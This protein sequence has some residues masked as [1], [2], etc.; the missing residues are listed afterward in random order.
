MSPAQLYR[1][2]CLS[3]H[4]TDGKGTILRKGM[5][6]LP[7]FTDPKWQT[8]QKDDA[9]LVKSIL[10]GKGKFMTPMKEK[11]G[12]GD[13]EKLVALVRGFPKS[14]PVETAPTPIVR[15]PEGPRVEPKPVPAPQGKEPR[16]LPVDVEQAA[17]RTRV[18][19]THYRQYCLSCHGTDGRGAAEMKPAM[20]DLP[21]F[22]LRSWQDGVTNAQ[23]TVSILD[24]KGTLM[25]AFRGRISD[26]EAQD[27]TAYIRAFGPV[28]KPTEPGTSDFEKRFRQ[29]EEE[30]NEW[31]KQLREL[32]RPPR[33][34]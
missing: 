22:A 13:A 15:Q 9:E 1:A 7:D 17:E 3:C 16:P 10:D 26:I 30:M 33:K 20:R 21:D 24:G 18:A 8:A 11:F 29:L 5:P 34:P 31:Q 12:V 25:P 6:D 28:R 32:Q 27:L 14:A 19:T 2:Y 23:L 4:D